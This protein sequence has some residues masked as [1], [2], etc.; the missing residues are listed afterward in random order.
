MVKSL[1]DKSVENRVDLVHLNMLINV[2]FFVH[3]TGLLNYHC[4]YTI[5]AD[6]SRCS[7]S[8]S[9]KKNKYRDGKKEAD[10]S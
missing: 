8:F 10:M 9:I 3:M 7:K 5:T 2:I 4:Y 6:I 1:N